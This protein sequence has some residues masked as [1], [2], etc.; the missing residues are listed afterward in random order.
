MG[1]LTTLHCSPRHNL[2]SA[3]PRGEAGPGLPLTTL[4][5]DDRA[6]GRGRGATWGRPA[7]HSERH[8]TLRLGPAGD[9][10]KTRPPQHWLSA[11]TRNSQKRG[12]SGLGSCWVDTGWTS[13]P[14]QQA[15]P[16]QAKRAQVP[17]LSGRFGHR[18]TEMEPSLLG[19][20]EC[21]GQTGSPPNSC[22]P[23]TSE[24]GLIGN[25]VFADVIS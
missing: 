14:P 4:L 22:S 1:R 9:V 8:R 6:E 20:E 7:L 25:R 24:C 15:G 16:R 21:R 13:R 18:N 12:A 23:R 19:A 2:P 11:S 10:H 17:T 5:S 3:Q